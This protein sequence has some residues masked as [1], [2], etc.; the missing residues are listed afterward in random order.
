VNFNEKLYFAVGFI[1][2]EFIARLIWRVE[3]C[4]KMEVKRGI[5]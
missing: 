3:Y 5:K 2:A 4:L 1:I